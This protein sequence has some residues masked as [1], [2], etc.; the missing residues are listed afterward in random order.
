MLYLARNRLDM[1]LRIRLHGLS[2]MLVA[3]F[4]LVVGYLWGQLVANLNEITAIKGFIS[5]AD[6]QKDIGKHRLVCIF[7]LWP[8][9]AKLRAS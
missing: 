6:Q 1:P 4:G 3:L 9:S 8:P 7:Y 2:L 5:R